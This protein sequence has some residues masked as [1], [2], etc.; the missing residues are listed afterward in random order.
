[1]IDTFAL[2]LGLQRAWQG[3]AT[4]KA[5]LPLNFTL[6]TT[7]YYGRFDNINDLVIDLLGV[8]CTAPQVEVLSGLPATFLNTVNGAGFGMELMLRRSTGAITG[9]LSYTLSRSERLYSCGLAPSDVDQTHVLNLVIQAR[10][11]WR[12]VAGARISYAT[13]RPYTQ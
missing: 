13:G 2:R 9:W 6:S 5:R 7:G 8:S 10:L 12:L 4:V 3:S 1:G 11:P